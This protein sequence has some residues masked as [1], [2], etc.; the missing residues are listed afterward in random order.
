M[1]QLREAILRTLFETGTT[2]SP[3]SPIQLVQESHPGTSARIVA[4]EL[5]VLAAQGLIRLTAKD[6]AVITA[7]GLRKAQELIAIPGS[8][9]SDNIV[10]SSIEKK[11]DSKPVEPSPDNSELELDEIMELLTLGSDQ[12]TPTDGLE[13]LVNDADVF[14]LEDAIEDFSEGATGDV[15]EEGTDDQQV[16]LETILRL[17]KDLRYLVSTIHIESEEDRAKCSEIVDA[18]LTSANLLK[19]SNQPYVV[20]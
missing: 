1:L 2:K 3:V 12:Q 16:Y 10:A 20:K 14:E 15:S 11:H 9:Y 5:T 8:T 4:S 17:T 18:I 19:K 13:V 6:G 7:A